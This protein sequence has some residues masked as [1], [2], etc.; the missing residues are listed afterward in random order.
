MKNVS[1][2]AIEKA[3]TDGKIPFKCTRPTDGVVRYTLARSKEQ[4]QKKFFGWDAEEINFKEFSKHR[5]MSFLR[6]QIHKVVKLF[7]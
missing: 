5:Q 3:F 4:C 6:E 7:K 2:L 1:K